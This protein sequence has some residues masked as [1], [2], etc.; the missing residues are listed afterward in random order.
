MLRYARLF[1]WGCWV[2]LISVVLVSCG[3]QPSSHSVPKQGDPLSVTSANP[4][5]A[6]V[7]SSAADA[8]YFSAAEGGELEAADLQRHPE[9]TVAHTFAELHSIAAE[10][11]A[12]WIDKNV[13]DQVDL[14]WLA[15]P[16][17]LAKTIVLVGYRDSLYAFREALDAFGVEGPDV[18]WDRQVVS[19][20][21]SAWKWRTYTAT[22][23][24]AWKRGYEPP[25]TVERIVEATASMLETETY[26][27]PADR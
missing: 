6:Q 11:K 16:A 19:P 7:Q 24:S 1:C 22:D 2:G 13:A 17:Q 5:L 26:I 20:G 23:K 10:K 27:E 8:V 3:A 18:D 15:E 9:L 14:A 21:F 4:E 25:S 12:I